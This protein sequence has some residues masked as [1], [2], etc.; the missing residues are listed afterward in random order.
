[1]EV[2]F[3]ELSD[4]ITVSVRIITED[5]QL[6]AQIQISINEKLS[7]LKD[8]LGGTKSSGLSIIYKGEIAG[9]DDTFIKRSVKQGDNFLLIGGSYEAKVWKRFPRVE[10]GD[11]FYMSDTYY[12]AV[13]FRAQR[14]V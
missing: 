6:N 14:D 1:M 11:Y 10:S 9:A 8:C 12:D 3:E 7:F 2:H 13:A 4:Q 5:S